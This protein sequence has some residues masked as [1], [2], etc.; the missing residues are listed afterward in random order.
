MT[1]YFINHERTIAHKI[2]NGECTTVEYNHIN[3][4]NID[5]VEAKIITQGQSEDDIK[6]IRA[7]HLVATADDFLRIH[8]AVL[9]RAVD[10]AF[11]ENIRLQDGTF[12]VEIEKN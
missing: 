12:I 3:L 9:Y 8:K 4:P 2:E 11:P 10:L 7:T 6:R 1:E 5:F